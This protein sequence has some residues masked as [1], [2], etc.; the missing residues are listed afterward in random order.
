[1]SPPLFRVVQDEFPF[2]HRTPQMRMNKK[3]G[4]CHLSTMNFGICVPPHNG[5]MKARQYLYILNQ[6]QIVL[7]FFKIS[8]FP[9]PNSLLCLSACA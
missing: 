7:S 5:G 3:G 2:C 9:F 6:L 4:P 8:I 1:M